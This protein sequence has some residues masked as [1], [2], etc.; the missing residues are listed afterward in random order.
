MT[1]A[2]HDARAV[3]QLALMMAVGVAVT[4]C[5]K[6]NAGILPMAGVPYLD[7]DPLPRPP[8]RATLSS[9]P[10]VPVSTGHGLTP[11][12]VAKTYHPSAVTNLVETHGGTHGVRTVVQL[13]RLAFGRLPPPA[14]AVEVDPDA[15]ANL[16]FERP[17]P[18]VWLFGA[19]GPCRANVTVPMV[20]V[21]DGAGEI[22]E[23]SWKLEGC[24]DLPWAP[25][26]VVAEVLP[27][28]LQWIAAQPVVTLELDPAT[29]W[30]HP[31]AAV[32]DQPA[33][34]GQP[35]DAHAVYALQVVGPR[36][37]PIEVVITHLRYDQ[38]VPEDPCPVEELVAA[39]HG[40]WND[41]GLQRIDPVFDPV[42]VPILLGAI[43]SGENVEALV[44][45]DGPNVAVAVPPTPPPPEAEDA[46][47]QMAEF[48]WGPATWTRVV[49]ETGRYDA[50]QLDAMRWYH[51]LEA[52]P[53]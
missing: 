13:R 30:R 49:V 11:D 38:E 39:T 32:V 42:D 47:Q 22:L 28:A 31:L 45:R 17:G 33:T 9:T 19:E 1:G 4:G 37:S 43:A 50:A 20:G 18:N 6:N 16:G 21:Y 36:P 35:I 26:G 14:N 12:P 51:P 44:Y 10:W 29:D 8:P 5:D 7:T 52:C 41:R 27:P 15:L 23:I 53:R 25:V 2:D 34:E 3:V 24:L 46:P 40:F 48:E